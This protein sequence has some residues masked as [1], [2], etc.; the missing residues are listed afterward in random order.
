MTRE[1]LAALFLAKA[2]ETPPEANQ[3]LARHLQ[4]K[5]SRALSSAI[6]EAVQRYAGTDKTPL[7]APTE[8]LPPLG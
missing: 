8:L 5:E 4:S 6:A 1:E 3:I 2:F 7:P